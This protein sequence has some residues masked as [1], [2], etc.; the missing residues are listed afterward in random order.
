MHPINF[1][2]SY[3]GR[4]QKYFQFLNCKVKV[5]NLINILSAEIFFLKPT[6]IKIWAVK[7]EVF[8]KNKKNSNKTMSNVNLNLPRLKHVER[9]LKLEIFKEKS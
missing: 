4:S 5:I 6:T 3:L 8:E 9:E 1:D 2:N 7:L